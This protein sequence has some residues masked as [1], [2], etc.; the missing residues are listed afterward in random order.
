MSQSHPTK[1]AEICCCIQAGGILAVTVVCCAG[2]TP[3]CT[4]RCVPLLCAVG[5]SLFVVL[6]VLF[7]RP[8]DFPQDATA[9][10][11]GCSTLCTL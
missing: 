10:V 6:T 9:A 2:C 3:L 4:G 1:G 11:T 7:Q 8:R 5:C